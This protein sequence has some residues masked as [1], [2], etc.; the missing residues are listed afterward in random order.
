MFTIS[1]YAHRYRK[2]ALVHVMVIAD[3]ISYLSD[4]KKSQ[5]WSTEESLSKEFESIGFYLSNHPLDEHKDL[6][7]I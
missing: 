1:T 6:L 3:P 2:D 7:K 4:I 5:D